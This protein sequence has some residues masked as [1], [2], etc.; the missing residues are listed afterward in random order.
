MTWKAGVQIRKFH[1]LIS[2]AVLHVGKHEALAVCSHSRGISLSFPA[3]WLETSQ[4][5]QC[6]PTNPEPATLLTSHSQESNW[7]FNENW[8]S[9]TAPGQL[10]THLALTPAHFLSL[11]APL[12][13]PRPVLAC[14]AEA[15]SVSGG[16][17]QRHS[18]LLQPWNWWDSGDLE[19]LG[20]SPNLPCWRTGTSPGP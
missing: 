13:A 15:H 3:Q 16:T 19:V 14:Y 18:H 11:L 17:T 6:G 12:S 7:F 5:S 1:R 2:S 20:R 8:T 9:S 10:E 4:C